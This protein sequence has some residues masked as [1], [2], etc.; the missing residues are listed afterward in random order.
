M[1]RIAR[2][3]A[4]GLPHHITQRG[5]GK[6][7]IFV[8]DDLKQTYLRLL[9]EQAANYR[10]R[11]LA[12][13][14]MTNHLHLVVIPQAEDSMASA[15]RHAH[16][17][18]AQYWNTARGGVGHMWQNRYYSCPMEACRVWPVMRYV[19]LNPLRGGMVTEA[20]RYPWSSAAAHATG[21]DESGVLDLD[22]W[23]K[24]WAEGD[25]L[26]ALRAD[27]SASADD[28]RRA[29]YTGRPLGGADFV[30]NLEW[31]LGRALAAKPGGRP[32]KV[33]ELQPQ[34]LHAASGGTQGG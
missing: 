18:F 10:L 33:V 34:R 20:V 1:A 23:H 32:K 28:I 31:K 3:V 26:A 25:W 5:N 19:E 29:T 13:C 22:W 8:T 7:D 14:L 27:E 30:A 11:V 2:V 6:R 4:V 16:G 15:L 17:R 12:Y 9:H 24:E 21:L